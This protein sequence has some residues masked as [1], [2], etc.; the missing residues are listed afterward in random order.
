MPIAINCLQGRRKLPPTRAFILPTWFAWIAN[1]IG[2]VYILVTTVLFFFPPEL[3][4]TSNNM[5]YCIVVF[6]IWMSICAI[7]WFVSGKKNYI[8][9]Q[10][11][12]DGTVITSKDVFMEDAYI[13]RKRSHPDVPEA[14]APAY[15]DA[16]SSA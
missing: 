9:P 8:G 3:P 1:I 15:K 6:G 10:V 12:V 5:N 16:G 11:Q 14:A 7:W 13:K 2:L 4:V